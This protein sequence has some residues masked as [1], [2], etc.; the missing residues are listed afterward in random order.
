MT[1][2]VKALSSHLEMAAQALSVYIVDVIDKYAPM[3]GVDEELLY[4]L[5]V[6]ALKVTTDKYTGDDYDP[7]K[8][9]E[10]KGRFE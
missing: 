6:E 3:M 9:I 1:D 10:I 2:E 5:K 8:P 7:Y 4:D